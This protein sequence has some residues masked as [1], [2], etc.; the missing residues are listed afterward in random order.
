MLESVNKSLWQGLCLD[1]EKARYLPWMKQ[2]QILI[3]GWFVNLAKFRSSYYC[4]FLSPPSTDATIQETLRE[5]LRD[6][7][8]LTIAH[9]LETVI[10]YDKILVLKQGRVVVSG[11][12]FS[13]LDGIF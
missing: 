9:R 13:L 4:R 5:S 7:T 11:F 2:R 3:K 12:F 6:K 8:V 10:D 1:W